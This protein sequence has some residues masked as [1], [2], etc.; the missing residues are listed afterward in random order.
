[1]TQ[2]QTDEKL[3]PVNNKKSTKSF[4]DFWMGI[5]FLI[6]SIS[7]LILMMMFIFVWQPIWT[8]GFKDFHTI[9][10]AIDKLDKTA[11]PASKSVPLM[12]VEMNQMNQ[13]MH[14]M[15]TTLYEMNRMSNTMYEMQ[16]IMKDMS[17]SIGSIEQ[18][19][20]EIKKMSRSID[21]MTM[22]LSTEIPRMTYTMD[23]VNNKMPNMGIMPFK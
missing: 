6:S 2:L 21:Q 17:A 19:T 5:F 15:N 18:M 8:E 23:R 10:N 22:V 13:N 16:H 4:A 3:N 11:Q 20:P 12:L 9:S 14:R 1:L 7:L